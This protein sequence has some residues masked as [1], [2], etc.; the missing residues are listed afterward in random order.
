MK[1]KTLLALCLTLPC[2]AAVIQT[3]DSGIHSTVSLD[4][5]VYTYFYEIDAQPIDGK[6]DLSNITIDLCAIGRDMVFG[7]SESGSEVKTGVKWDNLTMTGDTYTFS[8][9]STL[10]PELSTATLKASTDALTLDVLAPTCGTAT[11]VPEP[12]VCMLGVMS[13]LLLARRRK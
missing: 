9:R 13:V 6:H 5:G 3:L 11:Q 1:L 8:M 2:H 7:I 10:P 4:S 12:G